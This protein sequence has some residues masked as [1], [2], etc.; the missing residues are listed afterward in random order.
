MFRAKLMSLKQMIPIVSLAVFSQLFAAPIVAATD[1]LAVTLP[2]E[3]SAWQGWVEKDL[4][5]R[6]CPWQEDESQKRCLFVV[7][8]NLQASNAGAT[9]V[10]EVQSYSEQFWQ[11]PGE[12]QQWPLNVKI[13]L[14]DDAGR[15]VGAEKAVTVRDYQS[16]PEIQLPLGRVRISAEYRWSE[17][18]AGLLLPNGTPPVSLSIDGKAVTQPLW[19]QTRLLL[20]ATPS[21]EQ[22]QST[23]Q[24]RVFRLLTDDIPY[25]LTTIIRLDV[26]G[27]SRE[28]KLPMPLP[29]GFVLA[30]ID[31]DLPVTLR[32]DG[33]LSISAMSGNFEISLKA[34]RLHS[35]SKI[36]KPQLPEPWP[37]QEVW[38]YRG[39]S[40]LRTAQLQGAP[41]I[42]PQQ[43]D[44]P[45][46]WSGYAQ[47]LV[48]STEPLSLQ[49]LAGPANSERD[50]VRIERQMWLSATT[51]KFTIADR[52]SGS[53]HSS[54]RLSLLPPLAAGRIEVDGQARLINQLKDTTGSAGVEIRN[55]SLSVAALSELSTTTKM[56]VH[57]WDLQADRVE[58]RVNLPDGWAAVAVFGASEVYGDW[59]HAW[60]LWDMFLVMLLTVAAY[61]LL[62]V[63]AACALLVWLL[64]AYQKPDAPHW[65]WL[66]VLA[67]LALAK[68]ATGKFAKVSQ[69]FAQAALLLLGIALLNFATQ[70]IRYAVYPQLAASGDSQA[71]QELII[72]QDIHAAAPVAVGE[73]APAPVEAMQVAEQERSRME[74]QKV[75]II[76][77]TGASVPTSYELA[78]QQPDLLYGV[79]S[80]DPANKIQT[81]PAA[82]DWSSE[83]LVV[84]F[85]GPVS[86]E[87]Q[88]S[89][90]V[91]P[92]WLH[93][94]GRILMIMLSL[95]LFW[96]LLAPWRNQLQAI[97]RTTAARPVAALLMCLF[98]FPS[99]DAAAQ[100]MP[101]PE[102]LQE[103][104]EH[105]HKPALCVPN[106]AS[107]EQ[108]ML[109]STASDLQIQ[110]K[111]HS[112]DFHV[113]RL[114]INAD[115][116]TKVQMD[117]QD[118]ALLNE[119]NVLLAA[120]P[121]GVH[122]FDIHVNVENINQLNLTFSQHWHDLQSE[123]SKWQMT[124]QLTEGEGRWQVRLDRQEQSV[125]KDAGSAQAIAGRALVERHL[126]LGLVWQVQT[127]VTRLDSSSEMLRLDYPLLPGEQ[128]LT[129]FK[130]QDGKIQITLAPGQNEL[131]F[132]SNLPLSSTLGLSSQE[133]QLYVERWLLKASPDWH[134]TSSGNAGQFASAQ[135]PVWR[136]WPSEQVALQ[137]EKPQA[138]AGAVL[139][140]LGSRLH[141]SQGEQVQH[142]SLHL[143][144]LA[145]QTEPLKITLPADI[146]LTKASLNDTMLPRQLAGSEYQLQV[147]PGSHSLLLEWDQS[148]TMPLHLTTSVLKLSVPVANIWLEL[149]KPNDRWLLALGGPTSGP[150]LLFWGM[151]A[152]ALALAWLVVKSGF[153]PLKLRDG[154]LLFV[155]M[156]AISLWVPVVLSF[157]LVLVG[158]RGQQQALQGNWARLSVLSLVLLL[159]GAL[160]AL[161]IS[162]PQGLMSSPDMA[163]QH[164]HGGYNTLI[165][166]QDFA[167]AELPQAWIF[168]L[169]LWVYQIAMLSWALWLAS[170][171]LRWLPWC[172]QQLT[173]GGF[174]PTAKVKA[175]D[176]ALV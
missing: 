100:S 170:S 162:V 164:V 33:T 142:A 65:L 148:Q 125:N 146:Q 104:R 24:M 130:Q 41:S 78:A 47:Y 42:D 106:C 171:L 76:E 139:T 138:L 71:F 14:L 128:A 94:L 45:A 108:V 169:P 69:W 157:A 70:Q 153:T 165:W 87:Q 50:D 150:A 52:L 173:A 36:V 141:I 66:I 13:Q 160:L 32:Q 152:L 28:L 27:P 67:S 119:D 29:E 40:Q 61:R 149:E 123:L 175:A 121:A 159:S 88:W 124:P 64:L 85:S 7:Q 39:N 147:P 81:G 118:A 116:S 129:D 92:A 122:V 163:L 126:V 83:Q 136:P 99:P 93:S 174:W 59:L 98:A 145:S 12:Q 19:D 68:F 26:S 86:A 9:F 133:Q 74:K 154:I 56:P 8:T 103:L 84:N 43:S 168:S 90:Y 73:A 38:A 51:N 135:Q 55:S 11:L 127:H 172:W 10:Q 140:V 143:N 115:L 21:V 89:M 37:S 161:L 95:L 63:P 31:G 166:Y 60:D 111:V 23:V 35:D 151:L 167:Q 4:P 80:T 107:I 120:L 6:Y 72:R 109:K 144:L 131:W 113:Y 17:L 101:S 30:G 102:L 79:Q 137:F 82:P 91:V 97:I 57:G 2:P 77:V 44:A 114:P 75:E 3:L 53:L 134:V 176:A 20:R 16:S 132:N 62:G 96:Q 46:S 54:G 112:Q 15:T 49:V 155:G 158:W 48:S 18:P 34:L 156:S 22:A 117:G 5:E 58:T 1:N 105:L 25:R 110:M